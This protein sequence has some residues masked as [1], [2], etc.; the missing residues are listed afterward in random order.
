MQP[1]N[2]QP[3]TIRSTLPKLTGTMLDNPVPLGSSA[4]QQA[5]TLVPGFESRAGAAEAAGMGEEELGRG[6]V[7]IKYWCH[8]KKI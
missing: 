6:L 8:Y 4:A 5:G 1:K 7:I 2:Y 3:Q